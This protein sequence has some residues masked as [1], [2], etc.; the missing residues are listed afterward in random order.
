MI[1]SV[2]VLNN[3][4]ITSINKKNHHKI[5]NNIRCRYQKY[6]VDVYQ[7]VVVKKTLILRMETLFYDGLFYFQNCFSRGFYHVDYNYSFVT[8]WPKNEKS[9]IF[10]HAFESFCQ[11]SSVFR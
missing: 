8:D 3:F 6:S 11:T 2:F 9:F 1:V 4:K 10:I 7:V 5:S